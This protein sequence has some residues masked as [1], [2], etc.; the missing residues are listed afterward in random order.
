MNLYIETPLLESSLLSNILGIPVFLKMEAL[1]PSGS[2][3]NRGIGHMCMTYAEQGAKAFVCSSGGNAGLAAAY[4]GRKLHLPV[5]IV[6]PKTT[7]PLMVEKIRLEGAHVI[8]HG[9]CWDEADRYAKTLLNEQTTYIPPFDHPLIWKGN[10]TLIDELH[11]KPGA[12][13]AAVGGGGLFCGI[14]EGLH[15]VGWQDVPVIAVE[16]MGASSLAASM[17]AGKIVELEEVNTI[18]TSLGAKKV[19]TAAFE[20][21]QKH[22]VYAEL[23]TDRSAVEAAVRF[24][25]DHRLLVEPACGAALSLI[26]QKLPLLQQFSSV[27]VIVCGGAGVNRE[28][29]N[30]WSDKFK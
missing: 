4:S 13:I 15:R 24:A 23:V 21:T 16:T 27:V 6:V 11:D 14:L 28:M 30:S 29:L 7:L 19:C 26:Y 20:W 12:I 3:K 5:T 9:N 1:Q 2:F 10:S 18:A 8:I 22:S 25:D 17:Q